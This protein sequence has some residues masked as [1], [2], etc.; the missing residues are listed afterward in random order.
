MIPDFPRTV[1]AF[2]N[3]LTDPEVTVEVGTPFL[4]A[5]APPG[6]F[7]VPVFGL[8]VQ[9]GWGSNELTQF[10][11]EPDPKATSLLASPEFGC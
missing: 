1:K 3:Y 8:S 2:L 4:T 11:F 7:L 9:G 5:A 6:I 10:W